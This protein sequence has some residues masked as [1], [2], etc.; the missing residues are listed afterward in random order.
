MVWRH[1]KQGLLLHGI[2]LYYNGME[3][4]TEGKGTSLGTGSGAHPTSR[5][6]PRRRFSEAHGFEL[7]V[8]FEREQHGGSE[9]RVLVVSQER[10]DQVAAGAVASAEVES[11]ES[12]AKRARHR[13][14]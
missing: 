4:H 7:F 12:A 14:A 6:L 1:P 5:R 3:G 8:A 2:E 10:A 11:A 13:D 9:P